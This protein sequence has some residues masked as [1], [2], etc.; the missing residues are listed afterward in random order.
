MSLTFLK[1]DMAQMEI[2]C[3]KSNKKTW[4]GSAETYNTDPLRFCHKDISKYVKAF[5]VIEVYCKLQIVEVH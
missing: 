1:T 3:K 4:K 2:K 5:L